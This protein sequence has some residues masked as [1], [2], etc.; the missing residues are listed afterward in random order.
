M[1][2]TFGWLVRHRRLVRDYERRPEHHEAMVWWATVTIMTRRL[3]Q[4]LNHTPPPPRRG[5]PRQAH[6]VAQTIH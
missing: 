3:T 2:R 6:P 5:K 1:E 4:E